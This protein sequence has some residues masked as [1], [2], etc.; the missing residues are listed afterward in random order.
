MDRLKVDYLAEM[1][2]ALKAD[3]LAASKAAYLGYYLALLLVVAKAE[4]MAQMM[5]L[6][7]VD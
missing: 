1:M 6:Y 3:S 5:V 4:T 2:V 7:L